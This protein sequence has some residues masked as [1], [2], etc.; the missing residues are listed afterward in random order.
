[1]AGDVDGLHISSVRGPE[2]DFM[3]ERMTGLNGDERTQGRPGSTHTDD[4]T[5]AKPKGCGETEHDD[6][7]QKLAGSIGN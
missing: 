6:L 4:L 2:T 1:M 5:I 3:L 7:I